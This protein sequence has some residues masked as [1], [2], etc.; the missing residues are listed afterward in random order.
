[1]SEFAW[2]L[3]LQ[4]FLLLALSVVVLIPARLA[5]QRHMKD[6]KLKRIL[7][8]EIGSDRIAESPGEPLAL[9][10]RPGNSWIRALLK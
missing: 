6:S 9:P 2:G 8:R 7:L 3:V 4:P 10:N 1:M 5:I